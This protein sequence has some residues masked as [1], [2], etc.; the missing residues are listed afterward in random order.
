MWRLSSVWSCALLFSFLL[1]PSEAAFRPHVLS[2]PAPDGTR[3]TI[4][5]RTVVTVRAGSGELLPLDRAERV[6]WNLQSFLDGGGAPWQIRPAP[7][8]G[9]WAVF[10][11][12]TPLI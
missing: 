5:G 9:A 10:G 1:R 12:E 7:V 8:P 6:V 11:G 2:Q 4:S 3:V